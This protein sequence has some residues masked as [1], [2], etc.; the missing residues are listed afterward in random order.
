MP[1]AEDP[2][3][4]ADEPRPT[5]S[6]DTPG[7]AETGSAGAGLRIGD[8]ASRAGVSART[9]RY[10]EELGLLS[11]SGHTPGGERRYRDEDLARLDRI[12]EL[13]GV[14]GM[15]LDDI[16]RF[17]D[18]DGRLDQIREAYRAKKGLG[19]KAAHREQ[20]ALL[21]EALELNEVLAAELDAKLARMDEFR[22]KLASS[23]RRCRELLKD[24]D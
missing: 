22:S 19:T 24:L 15:N 12:L 17:L 5:V 18:S 2:G 8:A 23:A 4:T 9:L 3:S 13:R 11:P 16:K 7:G 6:G 10:Y 1:G 20:R 14:L 21:E